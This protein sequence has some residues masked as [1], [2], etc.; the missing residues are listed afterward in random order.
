MKMELLIVLAF[1]CAVA[2]AADNCFNT[3]AG[4]QCEKKV[5]AMEE[6]AKQAL[7]STLVACLREVKA[8]IKDVDQLK[9]A[10]CS[11]HN[12]KKQFLDCFREDLNSALL[13]NTIFSHE[14]RAKG[15]DALKCYQ[16]ALR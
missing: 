5:D 9:E 7:G 15:E 16:E 13:E 3:G 11:N 14:S 4:Q 8:D 1:C 10:V 2:S 6:D 12:L